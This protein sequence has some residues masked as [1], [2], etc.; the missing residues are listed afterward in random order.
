MPTATLRLTGARQNVIL[1]SLASIPGLT[2]R[3]LNQ[4]DPVSFDL[5]AQALVEAGASADGDTV[6]EVVEG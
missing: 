5:I 6:L 4:V 3:E 2:L 1:Q